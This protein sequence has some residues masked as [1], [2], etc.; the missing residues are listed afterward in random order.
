M[1]QHLIQKQ[2]QQF[3]LR[4]LQEI[5]LV[6]KLSNCGRLARKRFYCKHCEREN[7][8]DALLK[9][10]KLT[11]FRCEIHY[12]NDP[13]C[14]IQRVASQYTVFEE[15]QRLSNVKKLWH[16]VISFDLIPLHEFKSNFGKIRKR[17]QYILNKFFEKLKKRGVEIQ[18]LRVIDFKFD[19]NMMVQPHFHFAGLPKGLGRLYSDMKVMQ[20]VRKEMISNQRIKTPFHFQ[21]F[22]NRDGSHLKSKQGVLF[23]MAKR[24]AGL[25]TWKESDSKEYIPSSK[26]KLERD[27]NNGKYYTLK[28]V[29]T[30]GEYIKGFYN[31]SHFAVIG[32][33]PRPRPNGSI[34]T[35]G[36]PKNCPKHGKLDPKDV[37]VEI[38]FDEID[39][40]PPDLMK[41]YSKL[42]IE[43]IKI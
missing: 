37:R 20:E 21:S 38:I 10:T 3:P 23:Y 2:I 1:G 42:H 33:L 30:P 24:S 16:F 31:R 11:E 29:L 35:E 43:V 34:L 22:Q 39:I 17:Y 6:N 41:T 7:R 13:K 36:V 40:K 14:I 26:G 9:E 32:G 8:S 28:D 12:C 25:Y 18:A 5:N 4:T 27:I 15:M 19:K